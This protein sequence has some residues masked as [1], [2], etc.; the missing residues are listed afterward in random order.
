MLS[1][2]QVKFGS[3]NTGKDHVRIGVQLDR[4]RITRDE[5]EEN[6]CGYRLEVR[7]TCPPQ[8]AQLSPP[9]PGMEDA[10]RVFEGIADAK[11]YSVTRS[12][13]RSGLTFAIS[14]VD[15][16]HLLPFAQREGFLEILNAIDIPDED[17]D[18]SDVHTGSDAAPADVPLAPVVL[19]V[20]SGGDPGAA[21]TVRS[22]P[23]VSKPLADVLEA[24]GIVTVRN[25]EKRMASSLG[26][27]WYAD[28]KG[29]GE[30]KHDLLMDALVAFR[31]ANPIP[32]ETSVPDEQ[33]EIQFTDIELHEAYE[34]GAQ[35]EAT[36][37]PLHSNPYATDDPRHE[38]WKK[39]WKTLY[40]E[41]K[42]SPDQEFGMMETPEG[43]VFG[44]PDFVPVLV[45][46]GAPE[47]QI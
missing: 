30:S 36:G 10:D 20:V 31:R 13:I 2:T 34:L 9:L 21:A 11:S 25:L 40:E 15:A 12:T 3:V 28:I 43:T 1:K 41:T 17:D 42:L 29:V 5:A 6:F 19:N 38:H 39:G 37:N 35:A 4:N 23:G 33:V 22:L 14:A 18:D 16:T 45:D 27:P 8:N 24:A 46:T 32:D 47:G 26:G 44:S 7:L